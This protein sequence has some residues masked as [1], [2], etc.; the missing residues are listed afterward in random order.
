MHILKMKIF[1]NMDKSTNEYSNLNLNKRLIKKARN[2]EKRL[3][4]KKYFTKMNL[5]IF[6]IKIEYVKKNII[7]YTF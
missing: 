3:Q 6:Y 5:N 4:I 2:N 1:Y 7:I